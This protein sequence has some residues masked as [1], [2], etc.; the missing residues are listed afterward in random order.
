MHQTQYR[1]YKERHLDIVVKVVHLQHAEHLGWDNRG[2]E[3]QGEADCDWHENAFTNGLGHFQY[4][5]S[6]W[7]T[8]EQ[9]R[10]HQLGNGKAQGGG[11]GKAK[12]DALIDIRD[13]VAIANT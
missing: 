3:E 7:P 5:L 12:M 1:K 6:V 13:A 2:E 11:I 8:W 9:G 4:L 10:K